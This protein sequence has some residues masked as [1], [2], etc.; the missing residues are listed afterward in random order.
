MKDHALSFALSLAVGFGLLAA[1]PAGAANYTW[2]GEGA[3]SNWSTGGNWV[4]G[5]PPPDT[6]T[7]DVTFINGGGSSTAATV[8]AAWS[9][10]SLTFNTNLAAGGFT[11]S[12]SAL[13]FNGGTDLTVSN[14][15]GQKPVTIATPLVLTARSDVSLVRATVGGRV[16]TTF[17]GGISGDG[18]LRIIAQNV[19]TLDTM[20]ELVL[21]GLNSWTGSYFGNSFNTGR[22]GMMVG[23]GAN[24]VVLVRFASPSA[25]PTGNAG[26]VAYLSAMASL[27]EQP[28]GFMLTGAGT[29]QVYDPAANLKFMIGGDIGSFPGTG[30]LGSTGGSARLEDAEVILFLGNADRVRGLNLQVMDGVLTLGSAGKPVTFQSAYGVADTDSGLAGASSS[31]KLYEITNS[32]QPL[33]KAGTGTLKL[34]NVAYTQL[35]GVTDKTTMFRWAINEG[36]VRGLSNTD[37]ARN[38]SNSLFPVSGT[39]T[40]LVIA[41]NSFGGGVYEIDNSSGNGS[42]F[43]AKVRVSGNDEIALSSNQ[44]RG[45]GFAAFG[46]AVTVSLDTDQANDE[47]AFGWYTHPTTMMVF[48]SR[49]ANAKLTMTNP[50]DLR[51]NS[52]QR[53]FRIIDNP[54]STAD[55]T[56][57]SGVIRSTSGA[58][59]GINKTGDGT[60]ILSAANTYGGTTAVTGG[61]LRVSNATG[62]ATGTN[63]VTVYTGAAISGTGSVARLTLDGGA[64][65]PYDLGG[66]VPSKLNVT[67]TLEITAG[68]LDVSALTSLAP[69][70]HVLAEFPS[71]SVGTFAGF[72]GLPS[73]A[74]VGYT[75]TQ[76]TLTPAPAGTVLII[77]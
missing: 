56:E 33:V 47:I 63:V 2:N 8:N 58:G 37:P 39:A 3:D 51:A 52:G 61:V 5:N 36:A 75:T 42:T 20:P 4:G 27:N 23:N 35:D 54:D 25:L 15:D 11:L 13:T 48:G 74:M 45:G 64:L 21:G 77:E 50:I 68:I 76:I 26:E 71:Q 72:T 43:T 31:A 70:T 14:A 28:F 65:K 32:V 6:G 1:G 7:H 73:G 62:S 12:G 29:E 18:A 17:N 44:G 57:F 34:G 22:G 60:L 24:G 69:G 67:N 30:H 59:V 19:G 41:V 46:S 66:G 55:I 49:T 16:K 38:I 53:E 40:S 10:S 9:I